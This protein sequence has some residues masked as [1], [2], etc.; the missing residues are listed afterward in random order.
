MA[1]YEILLLAVLIYCVFIV[2]TWGMCSYRLWKMINGSAYD[3]RRADQL[4]INRFREKAHSVGLSDE[5]FLALQQK[6]KEESEK[7]L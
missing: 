3:K 6:A 4:I 7:K 5:E 1:W 2:I